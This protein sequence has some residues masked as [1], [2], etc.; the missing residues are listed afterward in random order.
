MERHSLAAV[1]PAWNEAAAIGD[2]V[3]GLREAGACCVYVVDAGSIDGTREE[4]CAAGGIVVAEPR[5]GY[6]RACLSGAEAAREHPLVAV[7][8]RHAPPPPSPPA[9]PPPLDPHPPPAP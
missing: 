5:R 4:A 6:G 2:V 8:H 9:P 1:V 3:R 7:L